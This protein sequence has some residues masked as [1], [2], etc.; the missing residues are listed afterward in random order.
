MEAMEAREWKPS[1]PCC[2]VDDVKIFFRNP[3]KIIFNICSIIF[4]YIVELILEKKAIIEAMEV[5]DCKQTKPCCS[6]ES[7]HIILRNPKNYYSIL[8]TPYLLLLTKFNCGGYLD[9]GGE[10]HGGPQN[11]ST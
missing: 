8:I 5:R 3:K 4:I 2:T 7:V 9:H 1:K 11:H 10:I 6:S